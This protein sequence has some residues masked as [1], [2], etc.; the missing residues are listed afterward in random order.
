MFFLF[1]LFQTGSAWVRLASCFE[2]THLLMYSNRYFSRFSNL[3]RSFFQ[4]NRFFWALILRNTCRLLPAAW[5]KCLTIAAIQVIWFLIYFI[6]DD[7]SKSRLICRAGAVRIREFHPNKEGWGDL[8][9]NLYRWFLWDIISQLFSYVT[10]VVTIFSSPREYELID[11]LL[12]F[13]KS[14]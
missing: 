11:M 8:K 3:Q 9:W 10:P 1:F 4:S 6:T 13:C 7:I 14:S 12:L 5:C 2:L